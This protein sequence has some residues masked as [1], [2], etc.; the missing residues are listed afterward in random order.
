[1]LIQFEKWHGCRNDF[2]VIWLEPTDDLAFESIKRQATMICSRR[3]DGIGSDGIIVLHKENSRDLTPKKLSVINS[4]G[5]IAKTC[6]NGIRC[7]ALSVLT[8][9]RREA[10]KSDVPEIVEFELDGQTVRCSFMTLGNLTSEDSAL[11]LV[12]VEM[13][14]PEL[15]ENFPLMEAVKKQVLHHLPTTHAEIHAGRIGNDHI[16]LLLDDV[17]TL[18]LLRDIGPKIQK[19]NDWDG[20]N[21]H[22]AAPVAISDKERT[23]IANTLGEPADEMYQALCW[24]RGAGETPA[25]GS[26][27]CMIGAAALASGMVNRSEWVVIDMPGGRLFVKQSDPQG[28]VTLAGP[29]VFVFGGSFSI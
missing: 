2:V 7:A 14:I 6:G 19:S 5:S 23:K 8:R 9:C 21:L 29:A 17:P 28:P 26:G 16:V 11:P 22:L 18:Q 10:K 20:I 3:G 4:D 12:A 13:G 24:E 15:D 25:C 27:A 1:M